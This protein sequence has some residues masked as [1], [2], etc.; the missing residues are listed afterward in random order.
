MSDEYV[1]EDLE[2]ELEDVDPEMPLDYDDD[3][4]SY[5]ED[6]RRASVEPQRHSD[7]LAEDDDDDSK[8][9]IRVAKPVKDF[10]KVS[11]EKQP[12]EKKKIGNPFAALRKSQRENEKILQR[13]E[14]LLSVINSPKTQVEEEEEV[15][16]PPFEVN[17]IGHVNAK[18]DKILNTIEKEKESRKEREDRD[19]IVAALNTADRKIQEF[20]TEIG[21][22]TYNDAINY[23]VQLRKSDME[24]MYPN[25]TDTELNTMLANAAMEEKYKL[26]QE[27]KNPG[28]VFY[29]YALRH[30]FKPT[31]KDSKDAP[32]QEIRRV[33]EKEAKAK[34]IAT[35]AGK[36]TRGRLSANDFVGMSDDEFDSLVDGVSKERGHRRGDIRISDL[37]E[38]KRTRY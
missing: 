30:G 10:N 19:N 15:D 26:Y 8:E 37:V 21:E 13:V 4:L 3:D 27:G 1:S 18:T 34:T 35:V 36:P 5:P 20:R 16:I 12:E 23:L 22:G 32:E 14:S 2:I 6:V 31:K 38:T 25:A 29:N 28:K 7:D 9:E 17:P 24:E 33:K 11:K